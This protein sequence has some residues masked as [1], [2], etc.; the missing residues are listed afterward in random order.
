MNGASRTGLPA[1][2][3]AAKVMK[4]C[5]IKCCCF[6]AGDSCSADY[7]RRFLFCQAHPK[8]ITD[9]SGLKLNSRSEFAPLVC[10]T[11]FRSGRRSLFLF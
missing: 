7:S 2:S 10:Y 6:P 11:D 9:S 8:L 5:V 1:Q 3:H 4:C